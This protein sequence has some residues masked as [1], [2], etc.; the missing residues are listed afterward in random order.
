MLMQYFDTEEI[1]LDINIDN[2][3]T[4]KLHKSINFVDI[5][6][7]FREING[8]VK[9]AESVLESTL[10]IRQNST[11]AQSAHTQRLLVTLSKV[12]FKSPLNE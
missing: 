3:F 4:Q 6:A 8:R 7:K 11:W 12:G 10:K 2:K 1:E 9:N 5:T